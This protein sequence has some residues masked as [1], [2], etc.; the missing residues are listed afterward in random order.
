MVRY[1]PIPMKDKNWRLAA[2]AIVTSISGTFYYRLKGEKA[3]MMEETK[4]L[5]LV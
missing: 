2:V 3:N 1:W 5:N 4:P